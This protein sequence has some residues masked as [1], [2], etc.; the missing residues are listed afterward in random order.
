[1][2]TVQQITKHVQ[3]VV[4]RT[5]REIIECLSDTDICNACNESRDI[6][7]SLRGI[8]IFS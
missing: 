5:Y 2:N 7:P 4:C 3:N 6:E 8:V 1:M